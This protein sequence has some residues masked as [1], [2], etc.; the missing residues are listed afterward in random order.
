MQLMPIMVAAMSY[1][2]VF[3]QTA[4][5]VTWHNPLGAVWRLLEKFASESSQ[6]EMSEDDVLVEN[7]WGI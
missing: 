5:W 3:S 7:G 1:S 2:S 4:P 6:K